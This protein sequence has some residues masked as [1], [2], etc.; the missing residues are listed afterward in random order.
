MCNIMELYFVG[1]DDK[2]S[3]FSIRSVVTMRWHKK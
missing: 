2:S 3:L 1:G